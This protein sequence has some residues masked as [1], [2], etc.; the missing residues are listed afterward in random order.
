VEIDQPPVQGAQP[1]SQLRL[2][3]VHE[4]ARL[5]VVDKPAGVHSHPQGPDETGT[6][7]NALLHCYPE[8]ASVGHDALQ[9]GLVHRLD[10]D[11]SGLML[12]A[13]D[14]VAFD[15]LLSQLRG[16][17]IDK[18]YVAI[19]EGLFTATGMHTAHLRAEGP[20]VQVRAGPFEG[21]REVHMEILSTGHGDTEFG[22]L[23]R[24]EV[25]VPTAARHQV[26]VQLALLGHPIVGDAT[27]GAARVDG[28]ER[29]LLHAH[30]LAFAHPDG[31]GLILESELPEVFNR[32]IGT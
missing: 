13:R 19:C 15:A 17:L 10:R 27:Y 20:Q 5:V 2:S 12:A 25:R 7:A 30:R 22:V 14:A 18:R 23:S 11:T 3:L 26:R 31:R 29:H 1:D 21:S 32:F 8:M 24:L 16:K 4:D 9:P 28:L 6:I